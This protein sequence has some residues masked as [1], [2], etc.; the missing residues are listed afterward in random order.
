MH[1][2]TPDRIGKCR[3]KQVLLYYIS[4]YTN[5]LTCKDMR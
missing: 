3:I 4:P 2:L 5:Y 1:N